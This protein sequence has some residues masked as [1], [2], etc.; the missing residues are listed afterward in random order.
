[1]VTRIGG[2][3]VQN[4][5]WLSIQSH[6]FAFEAQVTD[7]GHVLFTKAVVVFEEQINGCGHVPVRPIKRDLG[8]LVAPRNLNCLGRR[9]IRCSIK[10]EIIPVAKQ[11]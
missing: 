3:L 11:L 2:S 8:N 10:I 5:H 9:K 7:A 1:M 4:A 6:V